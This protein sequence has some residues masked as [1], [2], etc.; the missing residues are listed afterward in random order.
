MENSE[1]KFTLKPSPN[2]EKP[3]KPN[4]AHLNSSE[5]SRLLI[6][7]SCIGYR[8]IDDPLF[9]ESARFENIPTKLGV[10]SIADE[11]E[12]HKK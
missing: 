3:I 6:Q 9:S 1:M 4:E 7:Y 8:H 11:E 2:T 10:F 5:V 12:Y